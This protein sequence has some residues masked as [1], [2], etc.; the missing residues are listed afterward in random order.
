[1]RGPIPLTAL[2][3]LAL[4]ALAACGLTEVGPAVR[5][6]KADLAGRYLADVTTMIELHH[7]SH[8]RLP[9]SLADLDVRD[10]ATGEVL[11][12]RV[13]PDPWGRPYGYD[14][15]SATRYRVYSLGPDGV[16]GTADDVVLSRTLGGGR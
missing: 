6:G 10:P 1:M 13:A 5:A 7:L 11:A 4:L 14:L 3:L 16:R 9:D 15:L 12:S 2:P 8:R